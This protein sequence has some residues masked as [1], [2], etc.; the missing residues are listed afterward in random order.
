MNRMFIINRTTPSM[1]VA[2]QKNNIT[3]F[4]MGRV[5]QFKGGLL[6]GFTLCPESHLLC[7][8]TDNRVINVC[9]LSSSNM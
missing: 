6:Q 5:A 2:V 8:Y 1:P 4:T 9:S 3:P 7:S